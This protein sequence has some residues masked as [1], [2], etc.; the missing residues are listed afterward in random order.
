LR[1]ASE[2]TGADLI[3]G[4]PGKDSISARDRTRDYIAC[5]PGNDRVT[6]DRQDVVAKDC[7]HVKRR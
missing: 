1:N 5:G 7:E 2:G 6:A 4:G 3:I